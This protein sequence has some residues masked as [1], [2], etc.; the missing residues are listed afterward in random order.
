M[1]PRLPRI[2]PLL[3]WAPAVIFVNTHVASL[4][5]VRGRSMSPTLSPHSPSSHDLILVNRWSATSAL[6]RGQLIL[7]R[8]P[9]DPERVAIKRVIGIEGDVVRPRSIG[10]VGEWM[11]VEGVRV[12][13]GQ[14]WVEGDEGVHSLDSNV[15]GAVSVVE[16]ERR[17]KG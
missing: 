2:L 9:T 6:R 4:H 13:V 16:G 7:F 1:P 14:I 12:P 11:G 8:S 10:E 3:L 17:G 5:L 15:Y